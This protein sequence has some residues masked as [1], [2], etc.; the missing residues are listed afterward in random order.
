MNKQVLISLSI[1][2]I[3]LLFVFPPWNYI[4]PKLDITSVT[5]QENRVSF[6]MDVAAHWVK[7]CFVVVYGPFAFDT[8]GHEEGNNIYVLSKRT[9]TIADTLTLQT[10]Q[11]LSTLRAELWCDRDKLIEINEVI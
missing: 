4:E 8:Q 5:L 10:G 6:S 2:A 1:F 11:T 9:M 7:S 3:V